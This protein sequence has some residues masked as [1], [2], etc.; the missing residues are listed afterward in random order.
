MLEYG[1][2]AAI[3][4]L[5]EVRTYLRIETDAED[6][7]LAG[8]LQAATSL[9]EAWVGRLLLRRIVS[10]VATPAAG[11]VRLS[12]SPVG[13]VLRVARGGGGAEEVVLEPAD[14]ERT[15]TGDG[16]AAI[17]LRAAVSGPVRV[18]Y[19][20]GLAADWNGLPEG[21]RLGVLRTAAHLHANR[22]GAL[23]PGLPPTVR[24]LVLPWRALRLS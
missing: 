13:A 24:Q 7:M 3:A 5:A 23:D 6:A 18:T 1:K 4:P 20:A 9:V 19:E 10:E 17:A 14:W 8:L 21:L 16:R 2:A 11:L 12:A 22:D 15:A